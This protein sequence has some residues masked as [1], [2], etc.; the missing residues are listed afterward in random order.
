M[1][2]GA[3]DPDERKVIRIRL[4]EVKK[5]NSEK[6]EKERRQREQRIENGVHERFKARNEENMQR[7]QKFEETAK[8]YG[9]K[10][11]SAIDKSKEKALQE[12]KVFIEK[13]RQAELARI[14]QAAKSHISA[15]IGESRGDYL[16]KLRQ[17]WM[18]QDK[19]IDAKNLK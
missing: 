10:I 9:T 6:R 3:Q 7:M 5:A 15:N 11:E 8:S 2:T 16:T 4:L 12:K 1:L 19:H 14:D 17:E 18:L 13:E